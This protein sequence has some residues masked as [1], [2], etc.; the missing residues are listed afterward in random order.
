MTNVFIGLWLVIM[1]LEQKTPIVLT[2]LYGGRKLKREYFSPPT[3]FKTITAKTIFST[4][5]NFSNGGEEKSNS[6]IYVN[7]VNK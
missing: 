4:F 3:S 5:P 1:V 6:Y 2:N 7:I